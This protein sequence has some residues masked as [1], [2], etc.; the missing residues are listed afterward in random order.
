[1]GTTI[2]IPFSL[3]IHFASSVVTNEPAPQSSTPPIGLIAGCI[4][5]GLIALALIV[6]ITVVAVIVFKHMKKNKSECISV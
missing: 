2:V 1:M 4:A 5:G 3:C 6:I